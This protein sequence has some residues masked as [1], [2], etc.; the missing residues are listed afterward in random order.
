MG[1]ILALLLSFVKLSPQGVSG[2]GVASGEGRK[3]SEPFMRPLVCKL[4]GAAGREETLDIIGD[5][6]V[7][8]TSECMVE[9]GAAV[10]SLLPDELGSCRKLRIY[11]CE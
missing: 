4:L 2:E 1:P 8:E 6:A 11:S 7:L 3:R 9:F 5:E 10:D